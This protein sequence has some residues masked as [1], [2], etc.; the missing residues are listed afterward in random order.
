MRKL[1]TGI[2]FSLAATAA[3]ADTITLNRGGTVEGVVVKETDK[4]VLVCLKHGMIGLEKTEI[5]SIKKGKRDNEKDGTARLSGWQ[6]CIDVAVHQDWGGSLRQ[7]PATVI[8]QGDFKY[9]PYSSFSSGKYELNVYGDPELPA[10]IEIGVKNSLIE[11]AVAKRNCLDFMV[12]VVREPKDK[13]VLK[14]LSLDKDRK[15]RDGMTFEVTPETAEDAYGGWWVSVYD[16]RA[17]DAT[18]ATE[19]ELKDITVPRNNTKPGKSPAKTD[20]NRSANDILLWTPS[21]LSTTPLRPKP[22][23]SGTVYVRGYYRKN[24]TYVQPH[25]RSAPHSK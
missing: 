16:A 5:K 15:E 21:E 7:I 3:L 4:G 12:A 11:S 18:R 10:G 19:K 22:G 9:I 1:F 17:L 2:I 6:K 25:T 23:S 14:S 13:D 8:D 24:G 20:P